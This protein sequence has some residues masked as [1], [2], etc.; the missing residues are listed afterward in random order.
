MASAGFAPFALIDLSGLAGVGEP[1]AVLKRTGRLCEKR[2]ASGD[3]LCR[4]DS[5]SWTATSRRPATSPKDLRYACSS[6]WVTAGCTD[7]SAGSS[8]SSAAASED[9]LCIFPGLWCAGA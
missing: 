1:T 3:D 7:H 9:V 6:R 2:I 5:S 8:F 4:R